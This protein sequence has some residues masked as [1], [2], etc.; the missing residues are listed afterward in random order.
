[1]S[2]RIRINVTK[3]DIDRGI[4]YSSHACPVASAIRRHSHLADYCVGP[5]YVVNGEGII[6]DVAIPLPEVAIRFVSDF[7]A[8]RP[9]NPIRFTLE[10]PEEE[11]G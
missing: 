2:R 4:P 3:R 10:P 1:M 7:D 6:D 9:V 8:G 11:R 5:T